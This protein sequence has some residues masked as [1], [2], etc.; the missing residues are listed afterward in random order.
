TQ[1]VNTNSTPQAATLT[2]TGTNAISITSVATTGPFS[3]TN[4]CPTSLA[5]SASCTI[6]VVFTPNKG[7]SLTG[8]LSVTDSAPNSPQT[9]ALT[10]MGTV[11]SFSPSSLNFGTVAKGTSSPPQNITVTNLG[12]TTVAISKISITGARVT[13]FS[14]TNDCPISP[15]TL[16]AN[17]TCTISVTFTPQLKGALNADVTLLDTGG[18]SPQNIPIAGTGN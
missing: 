7:G 11:M 13:S 5:A 14:E 4:N 16:A 6:N 3:Q 18:G 17:G 1:L 15:S 8:T 9:A 2:N 10:G 12:A